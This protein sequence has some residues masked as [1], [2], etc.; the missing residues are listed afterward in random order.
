MAGRDFTVLGTRQ[1]ARASR[2]H[3]PFHRKRES[4][5]YVSDCETSRNDCVRDCVRLTVPA[6]AAKLR[7]RVPKLHFRELRAAITGETMRETFWHEG[8]FL[9]LDGIKGI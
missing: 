6:R 3:Y 8:C 1:R 4:Q 7:P 9:Q 5:Q 2:S